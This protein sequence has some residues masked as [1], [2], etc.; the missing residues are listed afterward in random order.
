MKALKV[1]SD[2]SV[3]VPQQGPAIPGTN[4]Y[5]TEGYAWRSK[6]VGG[7]GLLGWKVETISDLIGCNLRWIL[8]KQ[9]LKEMSA[10]ASQLAYRHWICPS[11]YK[12]PNRICEARKYTS[13]F[14]QIQ[15]WVDMTESAMLQCEEYDLLHVGQV[16]L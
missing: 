6:E 5:N 8:K 14:Q 2:F 16:D 1:A 9:N 7:G 10:P 3:S 12:V 11:K 15:W 4:K 13:V